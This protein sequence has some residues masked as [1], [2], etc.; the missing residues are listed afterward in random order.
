MDKTNNA[1]E[2]ESI[3]SKV[4]LSRFFINAID[5]ILPANAA[6]KYPRN[7]N[8]PCGNI[9]NKLIVGIK[10]NLY[11]ILFEMYSDALKPKNT[12][13]IEAFH[14]NKYIDPAPNIIENAKNNNNT[15]ILL[16]NMYVKKLFGYIAC[17]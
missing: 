16:N 17:P 10:I 14:N 6:K 15:V 11:I 12:P 4:S 13:M 9:S 8:I 7:S 3:I 1:K 2:S 5:K